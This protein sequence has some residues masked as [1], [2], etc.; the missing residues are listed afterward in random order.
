MNEYFKNMSKDRLLAILGDFAANWLAHDGAWFLAAEKEHG[1]EEAISLDREAWREFSPVE[2][3][4]IMKRHG[5]AAGGGLDAL[6]KAL[7]LR[8]YAMLNEQ[9][10][11]D[12]TPESFVFKMVDCRV[13]AARRRKNFPDFPCKSVGIVEYAEFA[14]AV[15]PRIKCECIACPPDEVKRD[16][17]CAWRFTFTE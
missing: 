9:E 7:G 4:R 17:F 8:M 12:E 14:K 16:C 1:M 10:I 13:Q 3:R 15:D 11:T 5:I 2:A 6:K